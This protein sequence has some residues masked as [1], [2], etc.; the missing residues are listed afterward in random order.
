MFSLNPIFHSVK[1]PGGSHEPFKADTA[2]TGALPFAPVPLQEALV[3]AVHKPL[4][5]ILD[6][7]HTPVLVDPTDGGPVVGEGKLGSAGL[8]C[9]LLADCPGPGAEPSLTHV[10]FNGPVLGL[11]LLPLPLLIPAARTIS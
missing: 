6:V 10:F 9:P 1:I 7:L 11:L 5:N 2:R 8:H 4:E 3:P